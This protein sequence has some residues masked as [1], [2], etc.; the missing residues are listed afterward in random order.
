M[1][2][3]GKALTIALAC[4]ACMLTA[5]D[6][7]DLYEKT[8]AIPAHSWESR[9]RPSFS[10]EI[11][12]T[13]VPYNIYIILRHNDRYNYNNIWVNL[14]TQAPG[15]SVQKAQYELPLAAKEKGWLGAS[16]GDVYEHRISLT[17]QASQFYFKKSGT[18]TYTIEQIM[19]EDPLQH[20]MNVG[21]RIEKGG[22]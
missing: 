6:T 19:R 13:T 14:V 16:M 15:D 3:M 2:R 10:F 7:I 17:P 18:Y 1:N 20:V 8:V 12:D 4:I 9:F 21:L 11:K 5:C 22:R